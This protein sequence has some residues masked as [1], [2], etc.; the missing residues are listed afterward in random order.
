MFPILKP[1]P[2]VEKKPKGQ[3]WKKDYQAHL[4]IVCRVKLNGNTPVVRV[5]LEC[6]GL[7]KETFY[8]ARM[9]ISMDLREDM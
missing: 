2:F 9:Q 1:L 4:F 5:L 3:G 7:V 6:V 8:Q